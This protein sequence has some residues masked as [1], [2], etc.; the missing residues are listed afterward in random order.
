MTVTVLRRSLLHVAAS[1]GV[2]AALCLSAVSAHAAAAFQFNVLDVRDTQPGQRPVVRLSITDPAT[3]QAYHIKT[4]PAFTATANGASRVFVQLGWDTREYT[5]TGSGS[6]RLPVGPGAALPIG[7]NVLKDALANGDGT[8]TLQSPKPIPVTATGTGVA[9]I[10]GHPAGPDATGAYTVRVPVKS[11]YRYFPIT[12]ADAAKPI[13]PRRQVVD[14]NKC[15]GCHGTLSLHGNNRTDEIQVCVVCHSPNQ[16]DINYRVWGDGPEVSIDFKRMVHA[17]HGTTR[18]TTPY[19]VIGHNH[20]VVDF[21]HVEFPGEVKRCLTCHVEGTYGVP[22]R[23][24]V[25][26]STVSTASAILPTG[27]V[28]DDDPTND[29]KITKTA[30]VCSSCHDDRETRRHMERQGASF[31]ISPQAIAAGVRVERCASCH[32]PGKDKDVRHVHN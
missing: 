30:A 13:V 31:S 28:I 9:V 29:L 7:I 14:V 27:T 1:A 10:E 4:H 6:A 21:S 11:V 20:T 26:G 5:N 2:A 16:T 25:L 18:R 12:V 32:G 19:V 22:L 23:P 3:G 15:K 24:E 17:I 8:Y